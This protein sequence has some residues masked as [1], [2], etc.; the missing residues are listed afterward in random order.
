MCPVVRIAG[1]RSM[2][3]HG[4]KVAREQ[5]LDPNELSSFQLKTIG[6]I[7]QGNRC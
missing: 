3:A 7:E 5:G 1:S 4:V 6:A 2:E